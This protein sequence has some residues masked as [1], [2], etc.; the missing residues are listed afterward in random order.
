MR[1]AGVRA[2]MVSYLF[3]I[4]TLIMV[5]YGL[6]LLPEVGFTKIGG[7]FT[8]IWLGFAGLV[9]MSH[10]RVLSTPS[11]SRAR[12]TGISPVKPAE[13]KRQRMVQS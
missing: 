11:R 5:I 1:K 12:N 10:L 9:L 2:P 13:K 3:A 8:V 6:P 4:V 7:L